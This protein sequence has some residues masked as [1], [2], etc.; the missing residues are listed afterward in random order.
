MSHTSQLGKIFIGKVL[1]YLLL[2]FQKPRFAR[3]M[4]L[5]TSKHAEKGTA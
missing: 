2:L 3:E 1:V 4:S 5:P